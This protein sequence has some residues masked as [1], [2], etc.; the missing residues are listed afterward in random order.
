LRDLPPK[1]LLREEVKRERLSE[2]EILE[3]VPFNEDVSH[4]ALQ[5]Q[6]DTLQ[7]QL[8]LEKPAQ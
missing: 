8:E 3:D 4:E 2:G 1:E 6:I 7:E 5:E